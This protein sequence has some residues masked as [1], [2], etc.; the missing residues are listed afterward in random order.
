[1][2]LPIL[3]LLA[4]SVMTGPSSPP[5]DLPVAS[6]NA[7][8]QAAD[9]NILRQATWSGTLPAD[10]YAR[11]TF[12][13]FDPAARVLYTGGT[14]T[15]TAAIAAPAR[16]DV[17]AI[18]VTN[19]DA[20]TLTNGAGLDVDIP[21][22]A[23]TRNRIPRTIVCDL[24]RLEPNSATRTSNVWHAVLTCS[25]ANLVVGAAIAL[26]SPRTDFLV[27]DFQWGGSESRTAYGSVHENEYGSRYLLTRET[28]RRSVKLTKLATQAD[29]DAVE[30]WCD[31]NG[32]AFGPGFLWPNPEVNDAYLGTVPDTLDVTRV[33]PTSDGP[34][35]SVSLAFVEL[36]KGRP[37]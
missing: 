10:T 14:A 12:A 3:L 31:G 17:L 8:F 33:A 11:A 18:P 5:D 15:I 24:S 9:E 19:A 28:M 35:F 7:V 34:V 21:I 20:L 26:Y 23:M 1:M 6:G 16:G 2:A 32:G 22:P 36:S 37:V 4:G 29:L 27:G 13:Q 30:A 25:T